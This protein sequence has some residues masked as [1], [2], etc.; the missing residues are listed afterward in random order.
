MHHIQRFLFSWYPILPSFLIISFH[1]EVKQTLVDRRIIYGKVHT[2]YVMILHR[3]WNNDRA[4]GVWQ[5][6]VEVLLILP[7]RGK[8]GSVKTM[9]EPTDT[10]YQPIWWGAADH[11]KVLSLTHAVIYPF[12]IT[13][14]NAGVSKKEWLLLDPPTHTCPLSNVHLI[15]RKTYSLYLI[16]SFSGSM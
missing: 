1:G 10:A 3:C 16:L 5:E 6:R 7:T 14:M 12:L 4:S 15:N 13:R 2:G 11:D 8:E 9:M